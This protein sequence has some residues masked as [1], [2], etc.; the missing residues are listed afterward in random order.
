VG[1]TP[2]LFLDQ[3]SQLEMMGKP[4]ARNAVHQGHAQDLLAT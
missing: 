2:S 3:S 4:A 1:S